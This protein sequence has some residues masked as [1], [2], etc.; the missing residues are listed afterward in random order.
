MTEIGLIWYA[1]QIILTRLWK[2]GIGGGWSIK[3]YTHLKNSEWK[4]CPINQKLG[5]KEGAGGL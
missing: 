3:K 1:I 4:N 2:S 5:S